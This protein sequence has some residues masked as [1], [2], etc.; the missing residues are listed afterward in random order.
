MAIAW[1][2]AVSAFA[3]DPIHGVDVKLGSRSGGQTYQT[4]SDA[5]GHFTFKDL[6]EGEY[7]LTIGNSAA[8]DLKIIVGTTRGTTLLNTK[9]A[10]AGITVTVA[11]GGTISG[12][13]YR[14][15]ASGMATG[16]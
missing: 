11:Q 13:I 15:V 16:R 4:A 2:S 10:V 9:Q 8:G 6:P 7:R 3:G 1:M 14:D 12:N 5:S